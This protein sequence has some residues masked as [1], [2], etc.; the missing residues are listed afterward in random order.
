MFSDEKLYLYVYI[1]DIEVTNLS[2]NLL[3]VLPCSKV[4]QLISLFLAQVF[5][6]F[7]QQKYIYTIL[8]N[9]TL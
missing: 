5:L 2:L 9:G 6:F 1:C 7:F 8:Y 3:H 4:I